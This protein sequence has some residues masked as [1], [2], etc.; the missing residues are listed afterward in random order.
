LASDST[1]RLDAVG[2]GSTYINQ[3]VVFFT[4]GASQVVS[5]GQMLSP[6]NP[7]FTLPIRCGSDVAG[8]AI[9]GHS[10]W[11]GAIAVDAF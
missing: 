9:D 8:I 2:S 10:G 6:S 7:T 4:N 5:V 11:N 3:V 1:L